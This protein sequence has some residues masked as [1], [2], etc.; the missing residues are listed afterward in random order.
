MFV[1]LDSLTEV[2]TAGFCVMTHACP[3]DYETITPLP[4]GFWAALN[5]KLHSLKL[6]APDPL[7]SDFRG[8]QVK[9]EEHGSV[10]GRSIMII[11]DLPNEIQYCHNHM[12]ELVHYEQY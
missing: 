2:K 12:F 8:Y 1:N 3:R 5:P 10:F 11:M 4:R 6:R 7:Y 9:T